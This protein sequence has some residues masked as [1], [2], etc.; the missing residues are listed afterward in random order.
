LVFDSLERACWRD[1]WNKHGIWREFVSLA[2][3]VSFGIAAGGDGLRMGVV[4]CRRRFGCLPTNWRVWLG[5]QPRVFDLLCLE[6][7]AVFNV[8]GMAPAIELFCGMPTPAAAGM[9][10]AAGP[11]IQGASDDWHWS[12][13]GSCGGGAGSADDQHHPL[14]QFPRTI[15]WTRKQP[16]LSI[17]ALCLMLAWCG[18]TLN[19][20]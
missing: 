10:A 17:V 15:P 5:L 9:L 20:L 4:A 2:D 14:L 8:Q 16:S 6:A 1:D 12:W 13:R 7:G 11:R 3:V 18:D 19:L